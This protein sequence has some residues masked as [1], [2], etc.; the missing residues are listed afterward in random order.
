MVNGGNLKNREKGKKEFGKVFHTVPD[1]T[2]P[3]V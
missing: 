3:T 1:S 2:A